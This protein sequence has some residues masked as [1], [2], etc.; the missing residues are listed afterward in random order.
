[1]S[2][3]SEDLAPKGTTGNNDHYAHGLDNAQVI[4][5]EFQV[6][7]VGGTP[8]VTFQVQGALDRAAGAADTDL[9]DASN[10]WDNVALITPDASVAASSSAITVTSAGKTIRYVAGLDLRAYR[11]IRLHVTANTNVTYSAR[12]HRSETNR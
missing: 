12:L 5:I 9:A 2:F 6:E 1:M 3:I 11:K 8:T 7:A 10:Q 4:A